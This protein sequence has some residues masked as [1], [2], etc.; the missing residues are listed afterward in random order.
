M[1]QIVREGF[2]YL[3]CTGHMLVFHTILSI[4]SKLAWEFSCAMLGKFEQCWHGICSNR[5]LSKNWLVQ[6]KNCQK[7][8]LFRQHWVFSCA[9]LSGVSWATLHR[10]FACAMLSQQHY[11]IIEQDF[12]MWNVFWR[13]LDNIAQGFYLCNVVSRLLTQHWTGFIPGQCFLQALEQH[14]TRFLPV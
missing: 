4:S 8:M 12:F 6:N 3:L 2:H 1:E 5:L 11:N 14:C 13:L 9:M 7:M 10:V